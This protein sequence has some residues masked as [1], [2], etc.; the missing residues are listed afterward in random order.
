MSVQDRSMLIGDSIVD[1]LASIGPF[2]TTNEAWDY[3][4]AHPGSGDFD[5]RSISENSWAP[6]FADGWFIGQ[7]RVAGFINAG[8]AGTHLIGNWDQVAGTER[9]NAQ[10][11]YGDIGSPAIRAVPCILGVNDVMT[12]STVSVAAY[13]AVIQ[14]IKTWITAQFTGS[15]QLYMGIISR[16]SAA[17]FGNDETDATFVLRL[18]RVRQAI[19]E[20]ADAGYCAIGANLTGH[21]Y[22]D[23]VHPDTTQHA[24]DIGYGM[25]LAVLGT[26]APRLLVA[27]IDRA[28][29]LIRLQWTQVLKQS[30]IGGVY[31]VTDG[32]TPVSGLT[33]VLINP[34]TVELTWSGGALVG[35]PG[36]SFAYGVMAAGLSVPKGVDQSVNATSYAA[37]AVPFFDVRPQPLGRI[38]PIGGMS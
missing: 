13:V 12:G 29:T 11:Y 25:V 7:G 10:N 22:G 8:V 24:A 34:T 16:A 3:D 20:A 30:G 33:A 23:K 6:K 37:P 27:K 19:I 28:A 31:R 38:M 14:S 21:N 36:V 17:N 5:L 9:T 32:G 35:T 26:P 18:N 4:R 15:P 2:T 1:Y